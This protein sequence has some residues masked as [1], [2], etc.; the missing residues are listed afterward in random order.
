MVVAMVEMSFYYII[1]I[2]F[3]NFGSFCFRTIFFFVLFLML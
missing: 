1:L 2:S 3:V